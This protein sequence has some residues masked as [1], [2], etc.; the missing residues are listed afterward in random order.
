MYAC[1][2]RDSRYEGISAGVMLK[3]HEADLFPTLFPVFFFNSR[4]LSS[5]WCSLKHCLWLW[6]V[7]DVPRRWDDE[8]VLERMRFT[9]LESGNGKACML[10]VLNLWIITYAVFPCSVYYW[11]LFWPMNANGCLQKQFNFFSFPISL[12]RVCFVL[13]LTSTN[14]NARNWYP[15]MVM[16]GLFRSLNMITTFLLIL[17]S[18]LSNSATSHV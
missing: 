14:H 12:G 2:C 7:E 3:G 17:S 13:V 10:N 5:V 15:E 18:C 1:C 8:F 9:L 6:L 11:I 16:P 4:T